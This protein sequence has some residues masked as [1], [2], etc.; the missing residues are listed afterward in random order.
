MRRTIDPQLLDKAELQRLFEEYGGERFAGRK[1][2]GNEAPP[3]KIEDIDDW[4]ASGIEDPH[5]FAEIFSRF[6]FGCEAEDRMTAVAFNPKLNHFGLKLQAMF[7][8]DIGHFDVS[9]ITTTVADAHE[10]VED[11]LLSE[12]DFRNF[13]FANV[14]RLYTSMNPDFFKGTAVEEAVK[15]L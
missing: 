14:A 3:E 12:E 5:E 2:M 6:Y 8:S 1:G 15:K 11:E 13:T 9:D 10:L 7:S 4:A